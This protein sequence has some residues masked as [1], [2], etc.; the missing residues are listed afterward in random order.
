M[1]NQEKQGP[2]HTNEGNLE[3]KEKWQYKVGSATAAS[4][5]HPN[6]NEDSSIANPENGLFAVFDGM[7]GYAGGERASEE[8]KRVTLEHLNFPSTVEGVELSPEE[9][10]ASIRET[11]SLAHNEIL[12][13]ATKEQLEGMGTTASVVKI[14]EGEN[15]TRKAIVGNVGDSR[16]YIL[17]QNGILEQ[18]TVDDSLGGHLFNNAR[19]MAE[20][21]PNSKGLFLRRNEITQAL[22]EE[23][24]VPNIYSVD[25]RN[26]DTI[27]LSSDGIHDNLTDNEIRDILT[28]EPD[29]KRAAQKLLDASISRSKEIKSDENIRP[30]KDDMTALVIKLTPRETRG[31]VEAWVMPTECRTKIEGIKRG[32]NNGKAQRFLKAKSKEEAY[33]LLEKS[34]FPRYLYLELSQLLSGRPENYMG[35]IE[36]AI[37]NPAPS[38][39]ETPK[40]NTEQVE[41]SESLINQRRAAQ[42]ANQLFSVYRDKAKVGT[43]DPHDLE[44]II[45]KIDPN[46]T[47]GYLAIQNRKELRN[48]RVVQI[49]TRTDPNGELI[50]LKFPN[51]SSFYVLPSLKLQLV[52]LNYTVLGAFNTGVEYAAQGDEIKEIVLCAELGMNSQTKD[53]ATYDVKTMGAIQIKDRPD[54]LTLK[55]ISGMQPPKSQANIDIQ[56]LDA[57]IAEKLRTNTAP[58]ENETPTENSHSEQPTPELQAPI[59]PRLSEPENI[60]VEL[61]ETTV[62]GNVYKVGGIAQSKITKNILNISKIERSST[63]STIIYVKDEHG[64]ESPLLHGE[65]QPP[66]DR[67]PDETIS[68]IVQI[69]QRE[70]IP[71]KLL[72]KIFKYYYKGNILSNLKRELTNNKITQQTFDQIEAILNQVQAPQTQTQTEISLTPEPAAFEQ[73]EAVWVMPESVRA[74]LVPLVNNNIYFFEEKGIFHKLAV[75]SSLTEALKEVDSLLKDGHL[76]EDEADKVRSLLAGREIP[77]EATTELLENSTPKVESGNEEDVTPGVEGAGP[78]ITEHTRE[79]EA[80]ILKIKQINV[81]LVEVNALIARLQEAKEQEDLDERKTTPTPSDTSKITAQGFNQENIERHKKHIAE[82]KAELEKVKWFRF[83]KKR[84]LQKEIMVSEKYTDLTENPLK[85]FVVNKIAKDHILRKKLPNKISDLRWLK[86]DTNTSEFYENFLQKTAKNEGFFKWSIFGFVMVIKNVDQIR[87]KGGKIDSYSDQA[88][89][90]IIGPDGTILPDGDN[91]QGYDVASKAFEEAELAYAYQVKE[92]FNRTQTQ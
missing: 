48:N 8:A 76:N 74:Y 1:N 43:W 46:I 34:D 50:F 12:N 31:S 16:V 65:I 38:A 33:D 19:T 62:D 60:P 81:E 85:Y 80:A 91:I 70:V 66:T 68:D 37:L 54:V 40:P 72:V 41:F 49:Q 36:P 79:A 21:D 22:G 20:L 87:T 10:S 90:K 84:K 29:S 17:R 35:E 45:A 78:L 82:T 58:T 24:P 39:P 2:G 18:V 69:L 55:Y 86:E 53:S 5:K 88:V 59:T 30:K 15:G 56:K 6:R 9:I 42:I 64:R 23:N 67:V 51:S 77:T 13:V 63:G 25:F 44:K 11:L 92:E 57:E 75:A 71:R 32:I 3:K 61:S 73:Q 14:W 47:F 27:L 83:L 7:G 26:N 4:E 52:S 28:G 89:Y